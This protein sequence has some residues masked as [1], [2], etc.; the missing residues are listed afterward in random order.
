[1]QYIGV[2]ILLGLTAVIGFVSFGGN[3]LFLLL[4]AIGGVLFGWGV[5]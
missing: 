1:M 4:G 5:G 3:V 2:G